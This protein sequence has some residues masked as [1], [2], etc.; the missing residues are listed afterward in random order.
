MDKIAY[1]GLSI[2]KIIKTVMYEFQCGY[3]KKQ[4]YITWIQKDNIKTKRIYRDIVKGCETR[5]EHFN[6]EL[7]QLLS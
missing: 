7:D 2:L 4:S 6:F 5:T 1:L 3:G